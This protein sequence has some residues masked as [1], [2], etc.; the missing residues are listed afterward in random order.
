MGEVEVART[1]LLALH[2]RALAEGRLLP[3]DATLQRAL[4]PGFAEWAREAAETLVEHDAPTQALLLAQACLKLGDVGLSRE[5]AIFG[6]GEPTRADPRDVQS[7]SSILA[8]AGSNDRALELL[9]VA[10]AGPRA[11]SA[12][13]YHA[14]ELADRA[15]RKLLATTW[16]EQVVALD[17]AGP[18]DTFRL[19]LFR[20]RLEGLFTRYEQLL[21]ALR[22]LEQPAPSDLAQ[23]IVGAVDLW[24]AV[25]PDPA[26]ACERASR[27]LSQL[28]Q[29]QLAWDYLVTPLALKPA[30]AYTWAKTATEMHHA[31]SLDL[32]DDAWAQAFACEP[33]NAGYL[34]QRI[35]LLLARGLTDRA[36][37]LLER[38]AVGP[39]HARF[40]DFERKA[41]AQLYA[42]APARIDRAARAA[43]MALDDAEAAAPT[44]ATPSPAAATDSAR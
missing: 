17:A 19:D 6:V 21:E 22:T 24:R 44:P 29:T 26:A 14:M 39:W 42:L 30:D 4:G 40:A 2:G 16:L 31:G 13:A 9:G 37:P 41:R 12:L 34:W 43:R 25:D 28:G 1:R 33:T 23:R 10:L 38:L 35:E 3:V 18:A 27:L 5:L 15:Q 8:A 32:A 7:A 36:L 20:Q 11:D